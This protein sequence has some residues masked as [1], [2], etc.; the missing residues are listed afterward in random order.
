MATERLRRGLPALWAGLL[1]AIG[2]IAAPAAFEL[3][4]RAD[5]GRLVGRLFAIEAWLG[6]LLGA[7]L[8]L[9]E[10]RRARAEAEQGAGSV[11]STPMLLLLG[12]LFCT[13]AG[14]F[15][16]L[17]MM[18]LARAGQGPLSFGALH[19][20][21]ALLFVLKTGLLLVLAWRVQR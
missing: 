7:G 5:A 17:P 8:L 13:V 12:A 11:L 16:L 15:A 19:A 10:R 1:L 2:G 21:S 6:L 18:D 4:A 14:H 20:I 3:L 9:L